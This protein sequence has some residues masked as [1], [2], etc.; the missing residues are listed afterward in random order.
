LAILA[1]KCPEGLGI[2]AAL[3]SPKLIYLYADF[4]KNKGV[5]YSE[6]VERTR[7]FWLILSRKRKSDL[8]K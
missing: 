2:A 3:S 6:K 5:G 8:L 4:F 1:P 7:L